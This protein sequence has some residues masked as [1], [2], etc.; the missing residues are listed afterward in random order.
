MNVADVLLAHGLAPV[1]AGLSPLAPS[2]RREVETPHTLVQSRIPTVPSVPTEKHKGSDKATGSVPHDTVTGDT[3]AALLALA[4]GNG[5][6]TVHV[7]RLDDDGLTLLAAVGE[8]GMRAFLLAAEDAAT[9]QAGKVPLDD[10]AA[11][12]C[13]HC[14]PVYVHPAIAACLPVVAG[15][16]RALGCPWCFIRKA[17]LYVPRPRI[18]CGNCQHFQRDPVSPTQGM[19]RCTVGAARTQNLSTYPGCTRHCG[20]WRPRSSSHE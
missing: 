15:W 16:P 20:N 1:V 17:G 2:P 7:H 19:G 13:Q 12:L 3:R 10:T 11:I 4:A 18:T 9:R 8:G 6:S 5:I 14:G